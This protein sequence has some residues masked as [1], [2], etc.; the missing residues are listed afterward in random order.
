[1]SKVTEAHRQYIPPSQR[2]VLDIKKFQKNETV[3]RPIQVKEKDFYQVC[4][5]AEKYIYDLYDRKIEAKKN[6]DSKEDYVNIFHDAMKGIP[7]SVNL[8]KKHLEDFVIENGLRDIQY[9]SYYQDLKDALFEETFGWG[10]L[11]TFK[12]E[13]D[14]EGA[15]VLGTDIKFKRSW[16]WETQPFKFRN[17][18]KVMDLAYR[19]SN[20]HSNT[21][22]NDHSSP[23]METRTHDNIRVSIMIPSRMHEEPVITLRKKLIS[24]ISFEKLS[25]Y[26]TIPAESIP[27]FESLMRFQLNSVIAG[28]PGCG[29]STLLQACLNFCLYEERNNEIIPERKVTIYAESSPEW[30]VRKMHRGSNVLHVIGRGEDFEKIIGSSILR[31]DTS[32]VVLGEI[33]EHEVGLYKRGSVQGIKQL[34]GTIHDLDPVD[35]PEILTNLYHQYYS[36]TGINPSSTYQSF[37]KNLHFSISM[38]EFLSKKE[39]EEKL[40]KKVTSIQFYEFDK[41]SQE[42]N[43]Y[44]IMEYDVFQDKW[45][46]KNEIPER[47][48][49]LITKYDLQAYERFVDTLETLSKKE[50]NLL[51]R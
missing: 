33:R 21:S 24:R 35:I 12:Y 1:M 15:Q 26:G 47:I 7:S 31:H 43:L 32:R 29:K 2:R 49:R 20:M 22:L 17:V 14:L 9:P 39:G 42:V 8:I 34:M 50:E 40:V 13:N 6:G 4:T 25:S 23:E 44:T 51:T 16:G 10:P 36:D 27:L 30:E 48:K 41:Y 11:A 38:D 19:F 5:Q 46:F 3:N 45:T 18:Q 37:S 28:P